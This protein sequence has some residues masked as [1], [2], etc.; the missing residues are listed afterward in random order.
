[1]D[2]WKRFVC[3]V[4]DKIKGTEVKLLLFTPSAT[5][6]TSF[7]NLISYPNSAFH[8][9]LSNKYSTVLLNTVPCQTTSEEISF[10]CNQRNVFGCCVFDVTVG[11][12]TLFFTQMAFDSRMNEVKNGTRLCSLSPVSV[13]S[14]PA[15]PPA[16]VRDA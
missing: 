15:P 3:D 6:E 12:L 8:S 4:E 2:D 9:F 5:M 7:P 11:V 13:P 14:P 1:M 10:V 16:L